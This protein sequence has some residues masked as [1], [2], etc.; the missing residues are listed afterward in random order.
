MPKTFQDM[1]DLVNAYTKRPELVAITDSAIRLATMR[2]HQVDFFSRD[3]R[4]LLITYT[5]P[6]TNE[7]YTDIA[8]IYTSAANLRTPY[9]I[10]VEDSTTFLPVENLKFVSDYR[11]FYDVYNQ[12]QDSIFTLLG[13]SL[14]I[15]AYTSTGRCRFFYYVN[16]V[17]TEVDYSSWIADQHSDELALWAAAIVWARSGFQE[18]AKSMQTDVINPFKDMLVTSYLTSKV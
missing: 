5:P 1:R 15:R 13:T 9:F 4:N 10:Q 7:L 11:D 18:I 8:D 2:A 16:P 12:V 14:R 3:Q 6:T 17:T